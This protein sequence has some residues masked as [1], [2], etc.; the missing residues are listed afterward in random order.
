ML[1]PEEALKKFKKPETSLLNRQEE[2]AK[3]DINQ[4]G[5]IIDKVGFLI[6][7]KTLCEI[8]TNTKIYPVPNTS[9]W[10][11]GLINLRGNLIPV[12]D[13]S[14]LIGLADGKSECSNLLVLGKGSDSVAILISSLPRSCDVKKWKKLSHIPCHL[15]GFEEHVTDAYS[16]NDIVWMD[17]NYKEYFDSLKEKIVN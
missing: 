16:S 14:V 8:V 5:F 12:Y 13:F 17:F 10:M 6:A 7:E 4:Y 9:S 15:S 1:K 2:G 11:R 3:D